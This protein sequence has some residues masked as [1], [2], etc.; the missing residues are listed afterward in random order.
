VAIG[1]DTLLYRICAA[2]GLEAHEHCDDMRKLLAHRVLDVNRS[3][4]DEKVPLHRAVEMGNW[5]C[6]LA[7][8]TQSRRECERCK[9]RRHSNSFSQ[10]SQRSGMISRSQRDAQDDADDGQYC[11]A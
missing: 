6:L 1:S 9:D 8:R 7:P 10:V 2:H 11:G 3:G 4:N 5:A